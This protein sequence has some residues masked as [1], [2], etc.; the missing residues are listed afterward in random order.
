MS[1]LGVMTFRP[2]K[3][4]NMIKRI[5]LYM[6]SGWVK[7]IPSSYCLGLAFIEN[8]IGIVY[9]DRQMKIYNDISFWKQ[10]DRT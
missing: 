9:N 8:M 3:H 1:I 2:L 6:Y 10:F 4:V 7:Q 5:S